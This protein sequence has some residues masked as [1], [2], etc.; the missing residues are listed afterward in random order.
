MQLD[1]SESKSSVR[2]T[3]PNKFIPRGV[4]ATE[5]MM[6]E[7][8]P[9][10][11]DCE[12]VQSLAKWKRVMLK[13]LDAKVGE[14]IYSESTSIRKGYKGDVTHSAVADQ[15][16]YPARPTFALSIHI[17]FSCKNPCLLF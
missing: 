15:C 13:R 12:V 4:I 11:M 2:F 1:G 8:C 3:V 9:Y 17:T 16:E 10:S 7:P 5:E 6:K 14:G